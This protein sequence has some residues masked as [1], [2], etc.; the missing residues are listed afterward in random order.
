MDVQKPLKVLVCGSRS[1]CDNIAILKRLAKLPEDAAIIHGDARG[2][3]R[4]AAG[5]A[6]D[7]GLEV[8]PYPAAWK[9]H[10]DGSFCRS[11][12]FDKLGNYTETCYGAGPRRNQQMLDS[13]RPELVIAFWKNNSPGTRDMVL[14][15][16]KAGVP[17]EVIVG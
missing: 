3:D 11:R 6:S 5:I 1:W 9:D 16:E 15:A 13:E 7:L 4:M 17:V 12:C 2:A 8:R 14:R 10:G